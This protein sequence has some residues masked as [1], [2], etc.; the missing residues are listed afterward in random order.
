MQQSM[1]Y[2]VVSA[3]DACRHKQPKL[4]LPILCNS[5]KP[6][7]HNDAN[8]RYCLNQTELSLHWNGSCLHGQ[9]GHR[10]C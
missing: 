7:E 8:S 2:S 4:A 5:E 10:T 9:P 1:W 3:I 6:V